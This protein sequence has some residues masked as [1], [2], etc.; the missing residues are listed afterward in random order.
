LSTRRLLLPLA[1]I[2]G[3]IL[4][5]QLVALQLRSQASALEHGGQLRLAVAANQR[6]VVEQYER[7]SYLAGLAL[8]TENWALL[9]GQREQATQLARVFE[10]TRTALVDGGTV[11]LGTEVVPVAPSPNPQVAKL[12][13]EAAQAWQRA[14]A[15]QIRMLRSGRK[16]L[17]GN[18]DLDE[19]RVEIVRITSALDR[20]ESLLRA[21]H[22]SEQRRAATIQMALPICSAALL[23]ILGAF[24]YL[25]M[26]RPLVEATTRATELNTGLQ[27]V[28]DTVDQ[29][30]IIVDRAN[31]TSKERSAA[32]E[33]WLG[34]VPEGS[35]FADALGRHHSGTGASFDLAL[36]TL[37]E[38][39]LPEEVGLAQLPTRVTANGRSLQFKYKPIRSSEGVIDKLL[40]VLSDV[41]DELER[42]RIEAEQIELVTLF[43][44]I[45]KDRSGFEAFL[46]ESSKCVELLAGPCRGDAEAENRA[47]H[48]LKGNAATFGLLGVA[49]LCHEI[50]EKLADQ[51]RCLNDS[52]VACLQSKWNLALERSRLLLGGAARDVIEVDSAEHAELV[53]Q[54]RQDRV[55]GAII[56]T[57]ATWADEPV[58]RRFERFAEQ[59]RSL[60]E[61]LGK[62]RVEVQIEASRVRLNATLW[63]G[64]WAAFVHAVRNAV[65]H[66]I[67]APDARMSRGKSP[68]G[69]LMLSA[70]FHGDE[71]RIVIQDDGA[72]ISWDRVK[73][74]ALAA[75]LPCESQEQL[76]EVLFR[77]GITTKGTA[78]TV[79]G[80][81]LGMDVLKSATK[82]LGGRIRVSSEKD[83]GTKVEFLFPRS[84]ASES[85]L[86]CSPVVRVLEVSS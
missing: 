36:D 78:T 13:S 48:T 4:L 83:R 22:V 27:L 84:S 70:E 15:A 9:I 19:F 65:D 14:T 10:E 42:R 37:F 39:F 21:E 49:E 1:L 52:D 44:H 68:A 12:L 33:R 51:L 71:L 7:S 72:G 82:A 57:L 45:A 18:A 66:G 60:A 63:A 38:G 46:M 28:L 85:R 53:E 81:G 69:K 47:L 77:Q 54:A 50:E 41:T 8:S 5:V 86:L 64:F 25:R 73:Q 40:V 16:E 67:E 34:P 74:H 31:R 58:H 32:L 55:P 24:I 80:R 17:K 20:T 30:L 76:V 56:A 43:Q 2:F 61:R 75:G 26:L 29:G 35:R 3:T 23:L 62:P 11:A 6:L 79:S 59:A